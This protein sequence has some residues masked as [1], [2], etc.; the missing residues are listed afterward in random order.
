MGKVLVSSEAM[1]TWR[2]Q[3]EK[4]NSDCITDIENITSIINRLN[5]SFTGDY[6]TAFSESFHKFCKSVKES[7][8]N[9]KDFSAFLDKIYEVM[10]NQ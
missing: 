6:E 3:M 4:V 1:S 10:S 8:T 9:M 7:H 5:E 2:T